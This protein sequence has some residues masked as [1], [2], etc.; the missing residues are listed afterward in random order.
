[1]SYE[2]LNLRKPK[3]S[4]VPRALESDVAAAI[5]DWLR[6]KGWRVERITAES[7]IQSVTVQC[8]ACHTAFTRNV[9]RLHKRHEIVE[10][11]T[12]DYIAVATGHVLKAKLLSL[13]CPYF[14]LELKRPGG[15]LRTSQKIWHSDAEKRGI[16]VCTADSLEALQKWMGEL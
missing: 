13:L 14:Y 5:L 16:P 9:S 6:L 1:M 4:E 7:Y 3:K 8:P 12:P 15:Q 10:E 11:G 2:N